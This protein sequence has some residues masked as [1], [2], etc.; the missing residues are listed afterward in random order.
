MRFHA[1]FV[2][3]LPLQWLDVVLTSFFHQTLTGIAGA[4][5]QEEQDLVGDGTALFLAKEH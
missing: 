4:I 2:V 1:S 5:I 3:W